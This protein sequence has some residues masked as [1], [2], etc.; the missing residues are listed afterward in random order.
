MLPSHYFDGGG[1]GCLEVCAGG[2][3]SDSQKSCWLLLSALSPPIDALWILV[4][5]TPFEDG[6][7]VKFRISNF[8]RL[9]LP[10]TKP[11]PNFRLG[12]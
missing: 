2:G 10:Q 1:G 12:T 9:R 4:I 11:L 6:V 7:C 3:A 8:P 5:W